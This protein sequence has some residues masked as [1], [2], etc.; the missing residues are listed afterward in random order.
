MAYQYHLAVSP[1]D[2]HLYISDP[3]KHQ[4]FKVITLEPIADPSI[5]SEAVST[6]SDFVTEP[7]WLITCVFRSLEMVNDAYPEMR[8]IV[9]TRVQ[10]NMLV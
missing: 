10:P 9:E 1:A 2:G 8:E 6:N 7:A 4:I 3:E 5:N